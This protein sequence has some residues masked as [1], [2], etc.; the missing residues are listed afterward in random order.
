[1][2]GLLLV[3]APAQQVVDRVAA[4]VDRQPILQSEVEDAAEFARLSILLGAGP[5]AAAP[6]YPLMPAP[7]RGPLTPHAGAPPDLPPAEMAAALDHLIN[8]AVLDEARRNE[9]YGEAGADAV[10]EQWQRLEQLAGGAAKLEAD[11]GRYRLD[12]A[13]VRALLERQVTLVQYLNQ[14]FGP[15]LD[16]SDAEVQRYYDTQYAPA[17]QAKGGTAAPLDKVRPQITAILREQRLS[18]E[19]QS[20]LQQLRAGAQIAKLPVGEAH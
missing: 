4:V 16:V 11:L 12:D 10:E 14:H 19:Q 7:A 8:Q 5:S 20:W 2:F 6:R 13:G 9:G 17:V 3:G 1:M 15:S 18:Q